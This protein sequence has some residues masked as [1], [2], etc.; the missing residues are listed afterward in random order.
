MKSLKIEGKFKNKFYDWLI[1]NSNNENNLID[2]FENGNLSIHIDYI[3][4]FTINYPY[5][6]LLKFYDYLNNYEDLNE[7]IKLYNSDSLYILNDDLLCNLKFY[8]IFNL[9]FLYL[10][11][12][13]IVL[14]KAHGINTGYN[15]YHSNILKKKILFYHQLNKYVNEISGNNIL[16]PS[17]QQ[18]LEN[19]YEVAYLEKL[20]FNDEIMEFIKET[21]EYKLI[22][23]YGKDSDIN[24]IEIIN[25]YCYYLKSND[26]YLFYL[27]D[28]KV[29][30]K[31][32]TIKL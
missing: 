9:Q 22:S 16:V 1:K 5:D 2:I 8:N 12:T 26:E 30:S 7:I 18:G 4:K 29:H 20:N 24:L 21:L 28:N 15:L 32:F 17:A 3:L 31:L 23:Y 19:K 11:D 13:S 27:I 14:H 6:K 10:F 25:N